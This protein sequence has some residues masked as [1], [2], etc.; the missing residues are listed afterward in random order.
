VTDKDRMRGGELNAALTHQL[1][2]IHAEYL[3]R[4]P[5]TA[6][7]FYHGN[8]IVT[9]M[10]DALTK[11]EKVLAHRGRADDVTEIRGLLH[12]EM[13]GDFRAAVERLTGRKVLALL[14]G[15]HLEPDVV[16]VIF[17]VDGEL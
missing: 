15:H 1:V 10:H 5:A 3:G 17:V 13:E 7:T 4:G 11:A 2:G 6:S 14:S 8:T 9:T 16:A 12:Q